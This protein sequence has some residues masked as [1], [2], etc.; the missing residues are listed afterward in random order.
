MTFGCV[1][2]NPNIQTTCEE[3]GRELFGDDMTTI[4]REQYFGENL[5]HKYF[6]WKLKIWDVKQVYAPP[7]SMQYKDPLFKKGYNVKFE[8]GDYYVDAFV[9]G[10]AINEQA[11]KLKKDKMYD[12][13]GRTNSYMIFGDN[14]VFRADISIDDIHHS[15]RK[16]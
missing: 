8:C 1:T 4:Q 13:K 10:F 15:Y 11:L 6:N 2:Y 7:D 5:Y 3:T 12:V 9:S 14:R 16:K